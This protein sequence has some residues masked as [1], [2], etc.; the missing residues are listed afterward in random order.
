LTSIDEARMSAR[1]DATI[2]ARM[3]ASRLAGK[4]LLPVAGVPLLARVVER[5]R[6]S[7]LIGRVIVA[8]STSPQDDAIAALASEIDAPCF[9]GSESD[10]LG[11]VIGALDAFDVEVHVEFQGDNALPEATLIDSVIG[12]FLERRGDVDYVSTAL[13]TTYPPGTEVAVYTAD[14]LRRAEA[15][16]SDVPREHVG[17]HIYTRPDLFRCHG[18]EA[19]P[20]LCEPDM[21]FEVDTAEDYAVVCRLYE[22]FVPENSKFT[23]AQ[24][25]EFA[26][27]SGI[28]AANV[29]VPRRWRVYRADRA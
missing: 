6:Q 27:A 1:I 20:S 17:P 19:P 7:T 22:H 15:A 3:G 5:I 23:I 21:H 16:R 8:T 24:A 10:V 29:D 12:F 28:C 2:Q 18:L 25:I 11:R 14:T 9:R 4:M 13:R 26:R